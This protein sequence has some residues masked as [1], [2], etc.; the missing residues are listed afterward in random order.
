MAIANHNRAS[1]EILPLFLLDLLKK[2]KPQMNWPSS[3]RAT[4]AILRI[5]KKPK[6]KGLNLATQYLDLTKICLMKQ[7]SLNVTRLSRNSSVSLLGP[8]LMANRTRTRP[9]RKRS[10]PLRTVPSSICCKSSPMTQRN[11]RSII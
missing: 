3:E 5:G 10:S 4:A 6:R 2:R 11:V 9:V 8:I 1:D 7:P